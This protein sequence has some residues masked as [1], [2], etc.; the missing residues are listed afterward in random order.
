M[1]LNWF[2]YRTEF[3]WG[4]KSNAVKLRVIVTMPFLPQRGFTLVEK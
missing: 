2:Y 1:K 3:G 4:R